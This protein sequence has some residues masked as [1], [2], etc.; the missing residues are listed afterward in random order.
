[1]RE[2]TRAHAASSGQHSARRE[3]KHRRSKV[4]SRLSLLTL[5]G[6]TTVALPLSGFVTPGMSQTV[7]TRAVTVAT[8]TS[9][10]DVENASSD[11]EGD[12]LKAE[13]AARTRA[14]LQEAVGQCPTN[15]G[16][17]GEAAAVALD[18]SDIVYFPLARG[19]FS[20]SSPFGYRVHPI[21]HTV[22]L[23]A[24]ADF[25]AP[26]GTD[27]HAAARGVVDYVGRQAGS[28]NMVRIKHDV[29]GESFYTVYMHLVDGGTVVT[30]G[31]QVE[32]GQVISHVGSTGNSTGAHLHFEVH[33]TLN[34]PIDPVPWLKSHHSVYV[35]EE[36]Q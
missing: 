4:A 16:A 10:V 12:P 23:H 20:V 32:A 33:P 1:M 5:L 19:T 34:E 18:T 11:V 3:P 9:W 30:Q 7:P 8:Q 28:G 14:R 24:G 22:R 2:D 31:Q 25:S 15:V 29:G 36:C 26:S 6:V 27:V 17:S 21:F 13:P 35:G